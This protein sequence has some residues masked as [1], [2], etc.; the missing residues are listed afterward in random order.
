ML[1]IA[2]T[3]KKVIAN[4]DFLKK[5]DLPAIKIPITLMKAKWHIT[6]IM[7]TVIYA[8]ILLN[9]NMNGFALLTK[10]LKANISSMGN[11]D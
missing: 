10:P 2:N 5:C 3:L 8:L 9:I 11:L 7:I 4:N 6:G 1:P